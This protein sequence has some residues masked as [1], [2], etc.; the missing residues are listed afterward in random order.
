MG[1]VYMQAL[2]YSVCH[3]YQTAIER[4]REREVIPDAHSS[5]NK[6]RRP[7]LSV[8]VIDA[9][10]GVGGR[11]WR[12]TEGGQVQT[13]TSKGPAGRLSTNALSSDTSGWHR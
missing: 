1:G 13:W 2:G 10:M 5:A 9:L 3:V 6:P 7:C 12:W 4:D 11:G 8:C